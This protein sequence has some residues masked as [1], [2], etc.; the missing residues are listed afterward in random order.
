LG[1]LADND[2]DM[3]EAMVVLRTGQKREKGIDRWKG[4]EMPK[5]ISSYRVLALGPYITYHISGRYTR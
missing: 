5:G 1:D 4:D 2:R 3:K